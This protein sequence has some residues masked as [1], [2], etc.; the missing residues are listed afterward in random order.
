VNVT[1]PPGQLAS[2]QVVPL[3]YLWPAPAW[4]LPLVP[5]LVAPWSL[6]MPAGSELPVATFVQVPRLPDRL[7]DWQAPLQAELQQT[8]WAQKPLLHCVL[9]EQVAPL[10]DV[11]HEL[12][13]QR[14]GVRH[15]V[16]T[17]HELKHLLPLQVY[18]LQASVLGVTQR[19]APSQVEIGV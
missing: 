8:P 4:H 9:A 6:H 14:L 7:Q 5:Q 15:W 11:P 16:S 10:L 2:A 19:P 1:V 13:A 18:G 17:V 3:G 12:E